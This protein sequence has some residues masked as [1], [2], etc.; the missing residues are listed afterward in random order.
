MAFPIGA[1]AGGA[2]E[3]I[4][5]GKQWAAEAQIAQ[6]RDLQ[7]QEA[8]RQAQQQRAYQAIIPQVLSAPPT[9]AMV[10]GSPAIPPA[11]IVSMDPNPE[12]PAS[13]TPGVA[14]RPQVPVTAQTMAGVTGAIGPEGM[15]TVMGNPQ[16]RQL[17]KDLGV[18]TEEQ[19]QKEKTRRIANEELR[20]LGEQVEQK[21][22]AKDPLGAL[23][24]ERAG[25][26]AI[27]AGMDD[28]GPMLSRVNEITKEF[29]RES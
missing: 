15:A 24:A 7:L 27:A 10:G 4:T 12:M 17:L 2:V 25:Y 14:A 11:P 18:Q 19:F 22:A 6:Y 28:P 9:T 20:A 21:Y 5:L 23:L 8:M 29:H 13:F 16:G 3:G 1:A 26:R